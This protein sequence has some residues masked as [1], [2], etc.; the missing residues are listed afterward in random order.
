MQVI[1]FKLM[2]RSP[3]VTPW[4]GDTL[5]G[6]ILWMYAYRNGEEELVGLLDRASADPP[7]VTD[8]FPMDI[9]P[10]PMLPLHLAEDDKDRKKIKS[11]RWI[12]VAKWNELR[13]CLTSG[14]LAKTLRELAPNEEAKPVAELHSTINRITGTTGE[15]GGLYTRVVRF[16]PEPLHGYFVPGVLGENALELLEQVG[17]HGYGADASTGCGQF[18]VEEIGN[19]EWTIPDSANAWMALSRH[20]PDPSLR[21]ADGFYRLDTHYGRLGGA[22]A[23]NGNVFKKPL[24][25]YETG[26]LWRQMARSD[27]RPGAVLDN[28]AWR[29]DAN[30]R[31]LGFTLP[32]WVRWEDN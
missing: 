26:S 12:P 16:H 7:V 29:E 13:K 11:I 6:H 23:N 19:Q 10:V 30:I 2:P 5:L 24:L 3:V 18:D 14:A 25:L 22:F 27:L 15:S 8:L 4:R 1:H 17:L 32:Y 9:L 28:M 20:L 31:H 21:P